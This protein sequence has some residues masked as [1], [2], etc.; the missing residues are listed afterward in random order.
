MKACIYAI[1]SLFD[2]SG[3]GDISVYELDLAREILAVS[4]REVIEYSY[5]MSIVQQRI[6]QVRAHK[7]GAA[8]HEYASHPKSSKELR[9]V[10]AR[11]PVVLPS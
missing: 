2:S 6:Y 3:I 7:P 1:E 10:A 5:C 8:G 4:A 9:R 11:M